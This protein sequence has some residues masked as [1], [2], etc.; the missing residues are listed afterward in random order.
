MTK[1]MFFEA[2]PDNIPGVKILSQTRMSVPPIIF[3]WLSLYSPTKP[4]WMIASL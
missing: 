1:K 4:G 3:Y 2:N